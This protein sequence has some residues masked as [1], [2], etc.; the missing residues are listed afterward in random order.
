MNTTSLSYKIFKQIESLFILACTQNVIQFAYKYSFGCVHLYNKTTQNLEASNNKSQLSPQTLWDDWLSCTVLQFHLMLTFCS[1][2]GL[3]GLEHPRQLAHTTGTWMGVGLELSVQAPQTFL[4]WSLH[5]TW[6]SR[7]IVAGFHKV[8]SGSCR[9]YSG[10]GSEVPEQ[11][12]AALCW[13]RLPQT[14]G[15]HKFHLLM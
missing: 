6:A 12:W 1:P 10:L 11:P 3:A 15:K 5:M 4:M 14:S 13:S 8:A 2:L 7:N 9:F